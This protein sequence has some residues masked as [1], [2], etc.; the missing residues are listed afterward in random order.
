M[1]AAAAGSATRAT[2]H[3]ICVYIYIYLYICLYLLIIVIITLYVY[4]IYITCG[5]RLQGGHPCPLRCVSTSYFS[6]VR[7]QRNMRTPQKLGTW[8]ILVENRLVEKSVASSMLQAAPVL[9]AARAEKAT[10]GHADTGHQPETG[11]LPLICC[12]DSLSSEVPASPEEF[13]SQTP[14]YGYES[15]SIFPRPPGR[16]AGAG[17]GE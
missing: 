8:K 5:G 13:F 3:I 12:S 2:R 17:G 15:S 7:L 14:L 9:S 16:R 11:I 4:T 6:G 1:T 10:L